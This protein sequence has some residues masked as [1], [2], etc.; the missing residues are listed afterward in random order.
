MNK[1][2]FGFYSRYPDLSEIRNNKPKAVIYIVLRSV[3]TATLI[4][5]I[6]RQNHENAMT[7]LLTL[8]LLMI[9][10]FI[11]RRLNIRLPN[12]LEIIV[13]SFVFCANI[14]GEIA[15]FYERIAVWD[16]IL[17]TLNGFV[18]AGVGFGLIDI[19]NRTDKFR[20]NLSPLFVCLFSFCFSMTVGTV[21]EFIE[22]GIDSL[23]GKDM[24]KDTV[25]HTINTV[26]LSGEE[27]TITTISG[28][29]DVKINAESLGVGGYIDIGLIDTM[30]DLLVNFIGAAVFNLAGYF[31]LTNR[32]RKADFVEHFIPKRAESGKDNRSVK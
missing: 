29:D 12:A 1:K 8:V 21:W 26:L 31:Y 28:I 27:N 16:T 20:V 25:I 14:L 7:C 9:P 4:Y 6:V 10:S 30:K 11:S 5:S 13:I 19:L 2:R 32:S 15:A 18:C 3:I 22:F 17:H 24:Q 23:F